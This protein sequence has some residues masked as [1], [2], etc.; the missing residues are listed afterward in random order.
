METGRGTKQTKEID[1]HHAEKDKD[2]HKKSHDGR[3]NLCVPTTT[4]VQMHVPS[5]HTLN[6]FPAPF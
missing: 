4:F 5:A 6:L 1:V 3:E 2:A